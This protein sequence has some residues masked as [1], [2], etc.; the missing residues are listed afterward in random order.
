M[1]NPAAL[2]E[3]AARCRDFAREYDPS[4]AQSLHD[5][6]KALD[7]EAALLERAGRERRLPRPTAREAFLLTRRPLFGKRGL[8]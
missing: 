3:R 1:T 8:P 6:A 2:R 4:T 5:R 7:Y